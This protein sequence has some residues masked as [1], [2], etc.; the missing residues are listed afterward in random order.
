MVQILSDLYGTAAASWGRLLVSKQS[1]CRVEWKPPLMSWL[2]EMP[3]CGDL[4]RLEVGAAV[5]KA[6]LLQA[7]QLADLRKAAARKGQ[8]LVMNVDV[9][10][11]RRI[12]RAVPD[13]ARRGALRSVFAGD[14][15]VR[16]MTKRWQGHDGRCM[17]GLAVESRGHVFS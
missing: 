16:S 17:C 1:F 5:R 15:V 7:A 12:L 6:F 13:A 10:E 14:C 3:C 11:A 4:W 8:S 9:Q 2:Q